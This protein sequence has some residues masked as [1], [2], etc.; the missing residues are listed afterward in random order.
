MG[1]WSQEV[2][3]W[4]RKSWVRGESWGQGGW[5]RGRDVGVGGVGVRGG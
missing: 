1:G 4:G 2:G 5:G 3:I